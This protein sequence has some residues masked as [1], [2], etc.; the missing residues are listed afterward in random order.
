MKL[1]G[2]HKQEYSLSK[3]LAKLESQPSKKSSGDAQ[4]LVALANICSING[5]ALALC[6]FEGLREYW[7]ALNSKGT[8]ILLDLNYTN[9]PKGEKPDRYGLRIIHGLLGGIRPKADIFIVTGGPKAFDDEMENHAKESSWWPV[10]AF[11]LVS[12][13]SPKIL[14]EDLYCFSQYFLSRKSGVPSHRTSA[15]SR[16]SK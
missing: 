2:I 4:Y 5:F 9:C 15:S 7:R 6:N 10:R 1:G 8:S 16:T 14:A 11:P 12:K 3:L 13:E